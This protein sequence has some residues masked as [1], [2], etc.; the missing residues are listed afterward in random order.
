MDSFKRFHRLRKNKNLRELVSE[1]RLSISDFVLPYFICEGE[2]KKIPI[3]SMPGI[4]R[5]SVDK[6]KEEIKNTFYDYGIK[7]YLFFGV[8]EKSDSN[9][10]NQNAFSENGIVQRAIREIKK[11]IP[12]SVLIADV[13]LCNYKYDGHCCFFKNNESLEIDND[14]TIDVLSKIAL[15]YA[16]SGV[17]IVAPSAMMDGQ[18]KKIR[19]VLDKNNF[20]NVAIMSYSAKYASNFYGPFREAANSGF[21]FGDRKSYQMDYRN[22]NEALREVESDI[23]EGA[24]IVMIKPALSYLDI[25][26]RVKQEFNIPVA[27]YNVSGEYS[28][29]KA[30]SS[31]GYLDEKEAVLEIL[32]GIKRAG[33][34]I[35]I[36][37]W[38]KDLSKW[39]E[40]KNNV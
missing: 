15:S 39:L 30:A 7:A 20:Q 34:D 32:T 25:I 23:K 28:M 9:N 36:S 22:S 13:C 3:D 26:Y 1:T 35:I 8:V 27:A 11:I 37:Y 14:R 40:D 24:D 2:N 17:D 33:A 21:K 31:K 16:K 18:V 5:F 29:I 6:L 10:I 19:E 4:F 38:A 12:D